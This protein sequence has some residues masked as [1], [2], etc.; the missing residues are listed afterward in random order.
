MHK[1]VA[2]SMKNQGYSG[3][4]QPGSKT[5]GLS[6]HSP[7]SGILNCFRIQ[8]VV[9]QLQPCKEQCPWRRRIK[10]AKISTGLQPRELGGADLLM[11]EN[12]IRDATFGLSKPAICSTAV[13]ISGFILHIPSAWEGGREGAE[14]YGTAVS[15]R[16]WGRCCTMNVL[17][18]IS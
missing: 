10:T 12:P 14:A 13:P 3:G 17:S 16:R 18:L 11:G 4:R 2:G 6:S 8:C 9:R 7:Q 5:N 1:Q 15:V